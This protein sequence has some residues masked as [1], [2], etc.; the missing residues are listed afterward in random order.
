MTRQYFTLIAEI[1]GVIAF[2]WG[3]AQAV[4]QSDYTTI[5]PVIAALLLLAWVLRRMKNETRYPYK[6]KNQEVT[7]E[8]TDA[9]HHRAIFTLSGEVMSNVEGWKLLDS[10]HTEIPPNGKI[11]ELGEKYQNSRAVHFKLEPGQFTDAYKIIRFLENPLP[12]GQWQTFT[13]WLE[14]LDCYPRER[15]EFGLQV[16]YPVE[17][18]LTLHLIFTKGQGHSNVLFYERKGFKAITKPLPSRK[19]E[20]PDG[21]IRYTGTVARPKVKDIYAFEWSWPSL[22][23]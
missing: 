2:G 9:E 14:L 8:F 1:L 23:R 18:S 15:E 20:L 19:I 7:L 22:H 4:I 3:I 12:R 13:H 6:F 16:E 11:G 10:T 5:F 17:G 21:S